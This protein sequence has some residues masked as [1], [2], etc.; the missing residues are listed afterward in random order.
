MKPAIEQVSIPTTNYRKGRT[1]AI[2]QITFHHIVGDAAAAIARFKIQG[3]EASSTFVISSTG[4]IYQLVALGDTPYT[5]A[6]ALSNSRAITIEHAG[7][8]ASVPYTEAMYNASAQLVAWLLTQYPI[9]RFMRHRDV[10]DKPTACPGTLNVERIVN[11]AK[12]GGN[13]MSDETIK[14]AAL[15][16]RLAA[17]DSLE[18]ANANNANDLKQIK[19]NPDYLAALAREIYKGNE[20]F[21]WK[22][23]HY[24]EQV[25]AAFEK[26]KLAGN[27]DTT[28]FVPVSEYAGKPTLYVKLPKSE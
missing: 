23:S 12:S 14:N 2:D 19:A 26:G 9:T 1:H 22:A 8:H 16:L 13:T 17:G 20:V 27:P 18:K 28:E 21:R 7:G 10:S 6:N 15:Y 11:Q 3:E 25:A 24:D 4:K 5:D